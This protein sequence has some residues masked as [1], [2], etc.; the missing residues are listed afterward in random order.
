MP[1]A[2]GRLQRV[3]RETRDSTLNHHFT[4][5]R[6]E[7]HNGKTVF[8]AFAAVAGA[9]LAQTGPPAPGLFFREDWNRKEPFEQVTQEHV[10]NPDLIQSTWGPGRDGIKKRHHG[11]DEDPY[12]IWSG[13]CPGNWAL[14]LGHRT[15]YADLT[16]RA[17]IRWR[18]MQTGFRRLHL[19]LKL[20]DGTW[21]VSEQFTGA[22]RDWIESE[23]MVGDLRWYKLNI[24]EV[25]EDIEVERADLSR[26]EEIGFTDLMR[27]MPSPA[28]RSSPAASRIDWIEVYARPVRRAAGK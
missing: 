19:I 10:A 15:A 20:A 11:T 12:Y 16:G 26:V 3:S 22:S 28:G 1:G 5:A 2:T 27:G 13:A 6:L 23:W 24:A 25:F 7:C 9:L 14:T 21:L 8:F 17:R 4:G 18:T